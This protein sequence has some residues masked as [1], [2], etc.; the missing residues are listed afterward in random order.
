MN[1]YI[2][3]NRIISFENELDSSLYDYP[4]LT[5]EQSEFYELHHCS[6]QEVLNLELNEALELNIDDVRI[7][8]I[9]EIKANAN[10]LLSIT[11]YKVIRHRDQLDG[12][13]ATT[14]THLEYLDLLAERQAIRDIS[15]S[16]ETAINLAVTIEQINNINWIE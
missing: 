10:D 11:D 2:I 7:N 5:N 3:D 12:A 13:M 16:L 1:H 4:K 6:L 14:L 15:N 8:K 9:N